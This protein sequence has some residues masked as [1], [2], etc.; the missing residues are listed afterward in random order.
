MDLF[1]EECVES[2][3]KANFETTENIKE[4]LYNN[5]DTLL[6]FS[7]KI[8]EFDNALY[9]NYNLMPL[10]LRENII[11]HPHQIRA[12]E[13]MMYRESDEVIKESHGIR[14]G[15]IGFQMG[16]GKSLTAASYIQIKTI[17]RKTLP[18][19][20]VSP[21]SILNEWKS[22]CYEKFFNRETTQSVLFFH[23]NHLSTNTYKKITRSHFENYDVVITTY[24]IL[25]SAFDKQKERKTGNRAH[26]EYELYSPG[27]V[28]QNIVIPHYN[29]MGLI[30]GIDY[31]REREP[32]DVEK[33]AEG[34][35]ALFYT[36]WERVIC[37]EIQKA[38]NDYTLT[39]LILMGL[40]AK[41]KWGLTGTPIRNKASDYFSELRF[42]GFDKILRSKDWNEDVE[43]H[44]KKYNLLSAI[45][46]LTYDDINYKLP[47]KYIHHY[48]LQLTYKERYYIQLWIRDFFADA[49]ILE[50]I[51]SEHILAV[52]TRLRQAALCA[53]LTKQTASDN[54]AKLM[55]SVHEY[56]RT[57]AIQDIPDD[58][59]DFEEFRFPEP[60]D[61]SSALLPHNLSDK[62]LNWLIDINSSAGLNSTKI[63]TIVQIIREKIPE[64][65][66][67]II[68]TTFSSVLPLIRTQLR[69]IG[70]TCE[71]ING[72]ITGSARRKIINDFKT[73][74]IRCVMMHYAIGA[75]GL[76]LTVANHCIFA[77]QWW[78]NAIHQ[79]AEA[80]VYR[81]GQRKE[82]HMYYLRAIN[83]IDIGIQ[84]LGIHKSN[85]ASKLLDGTITSGF[86]TTKGVICYKTLDFMISQTLKN[87][88]Y[89]TEE[90]AD[91]EDDIFDDEGLIEIDSNN[92]VVETTK[93]A[94]DGKQIETNVFDSASHV[95]TEPIKLPDLSITQREKDKLDKIDETDACFLYDIVWD[96]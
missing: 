79:Q 4:I 64:D 16:M 40:S 88:E 72:E 35:L 41:F 76:N 33:F 22:E 18:T 90:Q 58:I 48:N 34:S 26:G 43:G 69:S 65:E 47:T 77:D 13:Y 11:L 9:E 7:G 54:T 83:S 8:P 2:I 61:L 70:V 91:E 84:S 85:I 14:G 21:L 1:Y 52:F 60:R 39:Y 56:Q 59:N 30:N 75:E 89:V 81:Y 32:E 23:P 29:K 92:I 71:L 68:F 53:S 19:L 6:N 78:N 27:S 31:I 95:T 20:I 66:S 12:I 44:M 87:Y 5:F 67:V 37:D 63:R 10:N 17:P 46:N 28:Y 73:K 3:A 15:I 55:R 42:L 24:D 25:K 96:L 45:Y 57:N 82:T 80:R 74:K 51:G 49:T 36:K 62:M 93:D 94:D 86:A 50:N 38:A